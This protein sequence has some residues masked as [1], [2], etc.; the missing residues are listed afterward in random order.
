MVVSGGET[1]IAH[2]TWCNIISAWSS[3]L[4]FLMSNQPL[5]LFMKLILTFKFFGIRSMLIQLH[6]YSL[7]WESHISNVTP[8]QLC[9]AFCH[10]T[11]MWCSTNKIFVILFEIQPHSFL[12]TAFNLKLSDVLLMYDWCVTPLPIVTRK[13]QGIPSLTNAIQ[14][15]SQTVSNSK[16]NS[17]MV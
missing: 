7:Y 4:I 1:W 6:V 11:V 13:L 14:A 5:T 2:Y 12:K 16:N 17:N 8:W 9:I 10:K 15:H 3:L